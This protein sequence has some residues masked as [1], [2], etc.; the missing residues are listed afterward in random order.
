MAR[1]HTFSLKSIAEHIPIVRIAR[2]L[3]TYYEG[4]R[5]GRHVEQFG[6]KQMRVL[7]VTELARTRTQHAFR[8]KSD[9]RR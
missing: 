6:V 5:A 1:P 2:K 9:Y 8:P 3:A 4:W 7:I